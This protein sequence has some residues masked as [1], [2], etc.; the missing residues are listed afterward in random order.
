M[1]LFQI[2]QTAAAVLFGS[3]LARSSHN[4]HTDTGDELL[5][6]TARLVNNVNVMEHEMINGVSAAKISDQL[7][8]NA[9]A[10]K[11]ILKRVIGVLNYYF[12]NKLV[13]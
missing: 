2:I 5:A 4:L 6:E 3:T 12:I 9:L 8:M 13:N 10:T 7:R 1:R 11:H